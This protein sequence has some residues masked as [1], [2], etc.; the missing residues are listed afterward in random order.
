M[1]HWPLLQ[2]IQALDGFEL[3]YTLLW[4]IVVLAGIGFATDYILHSRGLGPYWNAAYAALGAYFGLCAHDWW[5]WSYAAYEP[6]L[7]IYMIVGGLLTALI[8]G[9]ALAMR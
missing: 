2:A 7:T 8:G 6:E 5:F 3:A 1:P 4:T 9:T